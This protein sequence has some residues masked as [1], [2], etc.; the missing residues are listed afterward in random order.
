[1][2][3]KNVSFLAASASRAA[4]HNVLSLKGNLADVT[5]KSGAQTILAC[6]AGTGA[7]VALSASL[8][9]E[10]HAIVPTCLCLSVV[11]LGANHMSMRRLGIPTFDHQVTCVTV[12]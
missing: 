3:G 10:F 5:A 7:G 8:G 11:H 1:S 2:T 4:I 9:S 12:C 6:M